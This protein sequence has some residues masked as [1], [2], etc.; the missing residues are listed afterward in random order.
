M[1]QL[2]HTVGCVHGLFLFVYSC[3]LRTIA[4]RSVFLSL[5]FMSAPMKTSLCMEL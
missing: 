4:S 2:N 5:K 1:L 3:V